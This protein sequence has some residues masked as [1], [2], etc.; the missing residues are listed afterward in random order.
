M[1]KKRLLIICI[2]VL[3]ILL[4]GSFFI[5]IN[6]TDTNKKNKVTTDSEIKE[7]SNVDKDSNLD[8]E[9]SYTHSSETIEEQESDYTH[10]LEKENEKDMSY[11]HNS[12]K[13]NTIKQETNNSS[14]SEN[15]TTTES[16]QNN[17]TIE[18]NSSSNNSNKQ[19]NNEETKPSAPAI[20]EN[21]D[22][23]EW[24]EFIND[25]ETKR[26]LGGHI[27][28]LKSANEAQAKMIELAGYGYDGKWIDTCI[29]LS[30]G[31]R[32]VYGVIAIVEANTCENNPELTYN[33]WSY[34]HYVDIITYLKSL[35][36]KKIRLGVDKGNPQSY[37]FWTKNGF[38]IMKENEYIL[39][40]KNLYT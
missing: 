37:R 9:N 14:N 8:E 16:N 11:T 1:K 32:C 30:T 15:K 31:K 38:N 26:I 27:T 33:W 35:G 28:D 21:N 4:I 39:M 18:D 23:A 22:E 13:E 3:I 40:E 24:E 6:N 19:N 7:N 5:I 29:I 25:P 36:C 10:T 2:I 20:P 34:D 12:K 17:E